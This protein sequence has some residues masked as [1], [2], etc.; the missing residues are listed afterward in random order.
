MST[1]ASERWLRF[2]FAYVGNFLVAFFGTVFIESLIWRGLGPVTTVAAAL[3]REFYLGA[4][5]AFFLGVLACLWRPNRAAMWVWVVPTVVLG[6]MLIYFGMAAPHS[7]IASQQRESVWS[8]LGLE[9][10]SG[11]P[12]EAV[13]RFTLLVVPTLR[14]LAYAMGAFLTTK[15]DPMKRRG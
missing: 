11:N 7:V 6:C 15:L 9:V 10:S 1:N 2:G 4:G 8:F 3:R 14:T 12:V 5:I 13:R